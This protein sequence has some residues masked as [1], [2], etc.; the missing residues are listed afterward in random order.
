M[1]VKTNA[2]CTVVRADESRVTFSGECMWQEIRGFSAGKNG[3]NKEEVT[4]VFLPLAADVRKGDCIIRGELSDCEKVVREGLTV[5]KIIV[6]DY[7]SPKMQ[8]LELEVK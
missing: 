1:G 7:G 3:E 2:V 5:V 6:C 4:I 8:H